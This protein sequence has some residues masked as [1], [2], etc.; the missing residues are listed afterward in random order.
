MHK[1][2]PLDSNSHSDGDS[3]DDENTRPSDLNRLSRNQ[4]LASAELRRFDDAKEVEESEIVL[5]N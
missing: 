3:E 2:P 4:L 1:T 5:C